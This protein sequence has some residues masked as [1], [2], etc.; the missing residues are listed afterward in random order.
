MN[1]LE[2]LNNVNNRFVLLRLNKIF[3]IIDKSNNNSILIISDP[4]INFNALIKEMIKKEVKVYKNME[5]LI[6]ENSDHPINI[7]FYKEGKIYNK[8][9]DEVTSIKLILKKIYNQNNKETGCIISAM[10]NAHVTKVDKERIEKK[11]EHFAFHNLYPKTGLNIYSATYDD[12]VSLV[13]IKDINSL[14]Y[15]ELEAIE[16]IIIDW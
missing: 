10:T 9:E 4:I 6:L 12:T 7:Y 14:E 3:Y 5:D 11:I 15:K 2:I 1:Y 13:I 16:K 8:N